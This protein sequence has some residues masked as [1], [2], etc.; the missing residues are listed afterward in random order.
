MSRLSFRDPVTNMLK[1]HG[2][3]NTNQK[4]DISQPE[5]D[6]FNLNPE[7][8]WMWNGTQWVSSPPAPATADQKVQNEQ[9]DLT[10]ALIK[11]LAFRFGITV[12]QFLASIKSRIV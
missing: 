5:A 1:C 4:N 2:Y 10:T 3:V 8:G 12:P 11:E 6:D 9:N 7:D